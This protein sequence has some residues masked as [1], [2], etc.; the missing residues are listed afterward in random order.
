MVQAYWTAFWGPDYASDACQIV[1]LLIP[2]V[3]V[4]ILN[5]AVG[6]YHGVRQPRQETK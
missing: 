3:F 1:A 2:A 5:F 4:F 6:F